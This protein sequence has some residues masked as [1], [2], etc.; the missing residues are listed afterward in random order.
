V[1]LSD[2]VIKALARAV[3]SRKEI[4]ILDDVFS[5]LDALTEEHVFSQ[6]IGSSG[7]LRKAGVTV[8]MATHAGIELRTIRK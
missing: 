1:V 5:G 4:L 7:L 2:T 8:V 3:Y 6:V